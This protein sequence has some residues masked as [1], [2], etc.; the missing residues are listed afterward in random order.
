MLPPVNQRSEFGVKATR[1]FTEPAEIDAV[2]PARKRGPW[3]YGI[4]HLMWLVL[5]AAVLLAFGTIVLQV[6]AF[7]FLATLVAVP[8]GLI[9]ATAIVLVLGPPFAYLSLVRFLNRRHDA[10]SATR[11]GNALLLTGLIIVVSGPIACAALLLYDQ[12]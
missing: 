9:A 11:L 5:G 6:V 3:Q 2:M 10:Q 7:A 1:P 8:V 4:S 12:L